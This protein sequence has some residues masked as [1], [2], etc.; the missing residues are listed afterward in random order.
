MNK[1]LLVPLDGSN[2]AEDVFPYARE[3][4]GRMDLDLV[5]LNVCN[6]FEKELLPMRQSY[7]DKMADM[8]WHQIREIRTVTGT[9]ISI[10]TRE[11]LAKVVIGDP[12]EEILRYAGENP[13]G[14]ILMATHGASGVRRWAI[15]S[16]AYKVLHASQIPV[17]L[18]RSGIPEETV[19]DQW[20]QRTI[21]VP[22]D[23]SRLAES[24]LPLAEQLAKERDIQNTRIV[25][26]NVCK[27]DLL[28][29]GSYYMNPDYPPTTPLQYE[30]YVKQ[31]TAKTKDASRQYLER[32]TQKIKLE[33]IKIKTEVLA[34][35]AAEE[36]IKYANSH[37]FQVIVMTSHGHSGFK[38][39]VLGSVAEKVVLE[40]HTPVLIVK[41]EEGKRKG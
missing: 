25:L 20:P 17:L 27:P 7:V 14:I 28:P 18:I 21:L 37:P 34:G 26:V 5:F 33:G 41:P 30:D 31:E 1:G 4:A 22:L 35:D 10:K 9:L 19:Y 6:P 40:T 2:L 3:I 8:V 36:I 16:V 11:A 12:G 32:I 15:G 23:G 39:L 38:H 24:A 13:I 29:Q